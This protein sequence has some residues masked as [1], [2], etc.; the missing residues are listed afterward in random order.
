M[1]KD[2]MNFKKKEVAYRDGD[3]IYWAVIF[4]GMFGIMSLWWFDITL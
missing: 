2:L 3:W 1:E 4:V